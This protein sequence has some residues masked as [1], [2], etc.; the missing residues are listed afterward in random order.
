MICV[1]PG[2]IADRGDEEYYESAPFQLPA[3]AT[4]QNIEWQAQV[5]AKTWVGAQL[6][7]ADSEPELENAPWLGPDGVGSWYRS[8]DSMSNKPLAE[9][10]LQYRLALAAVNGLSSP[11]ISE[12][13]ITYSS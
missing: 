13:A 12:V 5:P 4:V 1:D 3:G 10:W 8:G 7:W 11:R 2:N 9:R 6:R